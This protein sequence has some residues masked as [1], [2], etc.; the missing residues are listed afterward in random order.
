MLDCKF[1]CMCI[2]CFNA[3]LCILM[4]YMG[5]VVAESSKCTSPGLPI[6]TALAIH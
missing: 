6:T 5:S 4:V 3:F 2:M 1:T